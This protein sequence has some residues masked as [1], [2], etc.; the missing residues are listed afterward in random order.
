MLPPSAMN[1]TPATAVLSEAVAEI[2]I[3]PETVE[4]SEGLV[5][6]TAGGVVSPG[7]G[8]GGGGG[9]EGEAPSG[10]RSTQPPEDALSSYGV[11]MADISTL[12]PPEPSILTWLVI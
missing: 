1:C 5:I 4:P 11:G 6:E 2:V 9:G 12:F 10:R 8:G 3:T 7:G